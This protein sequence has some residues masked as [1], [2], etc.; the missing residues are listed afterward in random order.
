MLS[1]TVTMKRG[2]AEARMRRMI[3]YVYLD[4]KRSATYGWNCKC[5]RGVNSGATGFYSVEAAEDDLRKHM[6]T[7][8]A[9]S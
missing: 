9:N 4:G 7:H 1:K 5:E 6:D 3:D 8:H 2:A